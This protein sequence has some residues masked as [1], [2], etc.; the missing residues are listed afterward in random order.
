MNVDRTCEHHPCTCADAGEQMIE[1]NGS[2]YCAEHC[3][4][5]A[6][7]GQTQEKECGCG[8]PECAGG[9]WRPSETGSA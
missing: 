7:A 5:R 9:E 1:K 2:F 4:E 3:A 8:H 6:T